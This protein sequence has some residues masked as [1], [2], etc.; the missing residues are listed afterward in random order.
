MST[1]FVFHREALAQS[2]LD[3]LLGEGLQDYSS[4]LFLA[5]PRRTGKSTFLREDLIPLLL[6]TGWLP[7]YVDLWSNKQADP[8]QLIE[9]AIMSTLQE[10]EPQ[11]K[12]ALKSAGIEKINLLRS[13]SWD[14]TRA[15][16]PENATLA[17]ALQLL[18]VASKQRVVLIVDEAQHALNSENG[19]NAMFALKAARDAMNQGVDTEGLRLVFTGS[20]RDKLAQLVLNR[21]QPF[22]GA[23]I[24]PFPLLGDDFVAAYTQDINAKLAEQNRFQIN[25]MKRAFQLVGSRPELLTAIVQRVA[26]VLGEASNL[27]ELLEEG[28][29]EI[30]AGVWAEYEAAYGPL[31]PAQK[32]V[33]QVM[34]EHLSHQKA[35][36]AY[37]ESTVARVGEITAK[38][39]GNTT[40][41]AQT[42]Q[43]ALETLREKE[44]VWRSGRGAY[45]LEDN[46]MADW[47]L[48]HH[49]IDRSARR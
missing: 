29:A 7:V 30:Q 14:L 9:H 11:F 40:P 45:A 8:G 32:A 21:H 6:S 20:S 10:F 23:M 1:R 12:K 17:D 41:T 37:S 2:I 42:I 34:A 43:A 27:G 38:L 4:G 39:D 46:G 35:F 22:F 47:L 3:G 31:T 44:L 18:H 19:I 5:A 15:A 24:T 36:A 13:V 33:L 48:S 28:A 25:D 26:L 16:L 49:S